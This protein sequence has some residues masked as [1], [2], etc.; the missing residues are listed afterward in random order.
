MKKNEE[1]QVQEEEEE[2]DNRTENLD[3]SDDDDDLEILGQNFQLPPP[4]QQ[5]I[6]QQQRIIPK[7]TPLQ[8]A[9]DRLND[10]APTY[11]FI[12]LGIENYHNAFKDLI[13]DVNVIT[14]FIINDVTTATKTFKNT[15]E[16]NYPE[17]KNGQENELFQEFIIA[18]KEME[19]AA[20]N[21]KEINE[22]ILKKFEENIKKEKDGEKLTKKECDKKL[23]IKPEEILEPKPGPSGINHGQ[24]NLSNNSFPNLLSITELNNV[25]K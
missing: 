3:D 18:Q 11:E 19:K 10:G 1:V 23:E 15:F 17:L 12:P 21:Q 2:N 8:I 4:Q 22:K 6:Q 25:K 13:N 9:I 14:E 5:L 20:K 16:T 24:R 7:R